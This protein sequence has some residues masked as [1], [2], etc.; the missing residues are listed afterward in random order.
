M[1]ILAGN[2]VNNNE[3]VVQSQ[4][5]ATIGFLLVRFFTNGNRGKGQ[6]LLLVSL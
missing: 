4:Q 6:T 2:C 1:H 5:I 3:W